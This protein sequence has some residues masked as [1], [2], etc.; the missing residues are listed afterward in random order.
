MDDFN[1]RAQSGPD[2]EAHELMRK[3]VIT[4]ILYGVYAGI[5]L[6]T[7]SILVIK[8]I[9]DSVGE[10]WIIGGIVGGAFLLFEVCGLIGFKMRS[11]GIPLIGG[12]YEP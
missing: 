3:A 5:I 8:A 10:F 1:P 12:D 2:S 6:A 7:M 9:F 4:L 11:L